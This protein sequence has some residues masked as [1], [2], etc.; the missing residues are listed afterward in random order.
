MSTEQQVKGYVPE[1]IPTLKPQRADGYQL[2]AD[3]DQLRATGVSFWEKVQVVGTFL[4]G[5]GAT[6]MGLSMI[7]TIATELL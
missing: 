1:Q 5:L 2:L 7:Y 6:L 4:I 3:G